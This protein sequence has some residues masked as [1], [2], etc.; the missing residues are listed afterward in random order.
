MAGTAISLR[1]VASFSAVQAQA[2][3]RDTRPCHG[4]IAFALTPQFTGGASL[5]RTGDLRIMIPLL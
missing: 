3:A 1:H 4:V 5:T 2:H